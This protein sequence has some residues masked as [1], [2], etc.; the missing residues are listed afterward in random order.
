MNND[1][2]NENQLANDLKPVVFELETNYETYLLELNNNSILI[3][4]KMALINKI[5]SMGIMERLATLIYIFSLK[6]NPSITINL[7]NKIAE[8]VLNE[9]QY[10]IV[11]LSLNL[12]EEFLLRYQQVFTQKGKK[13]LVR[14]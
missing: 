2:L 14:R 5:D 7:A 10:D 8:T 4:D 1:V 6:H 3:A 13:K 9:G 11:D 12:V